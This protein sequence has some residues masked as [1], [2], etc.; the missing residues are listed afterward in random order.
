MMEHDVDA[1]AKNFGS[2]LKTLLGRKNAMS[3]H[4]SPPNDNIKKRNM[5][6]SPNSK[7]NVHNEELKDL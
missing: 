3:G 7:K 6:F 2:Q 1:N 5:S 4:H